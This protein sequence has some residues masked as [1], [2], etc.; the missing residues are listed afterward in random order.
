MRRGSGEPLRWAGIVAGVVL[1]S[2]TRPRGW[3]SFPVSSFPMFSRDDLGTVGSPAHVL[4]VLPDGTERPARFSSSLVA[5]R[6]TTHGWIV[7][8]WLF[9]VG[10]SRRWR[11]ASSTRSPLTGAAFATML[12]L[13]R[14]PIVNGQWWRR[15]RTGAAAGRW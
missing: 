8:A 7:L 2:L 5:S 9:H 10:I 3:D 6:R 14:V 12:P 11:L 13:E 1:S 4:L 15:R